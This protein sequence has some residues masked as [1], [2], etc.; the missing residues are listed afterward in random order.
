MYKVF[1]TGA[2]GYIGGHLVES[3]LAEGHHVRCLLRHNGRKAALPIQC[4]SNLEC[5]TGDLQDTLRLREW[6]RDCDLVYHLAGLTSARFRHDLYRTNVTG[7]GAVAEACAMQRRPPRLIIVSSLAAAGTATKGH[8]RSSADASRPVSEYGRSKRAGELAAIR[9]ANQVPIS[10]VRPGIVFGERNREMLP[11]FQSIAQFRLHAVP[12]YV[13]RRVSLV[14]HEDLITLLRQIQQRGRTVRTNGSDRG[15]GIYF[16]AD[17]QHVSYA[18]L[19]RMIARSL[20]QRRALILPIAEP[21]AWL[22][23][24]G[25]QG[26]NFLRGRSDSF[27]LDKM[28]EA[29]AGDWIGATESLQSEFNFRPAK[30]LQARL[31]QTAR[32]YREQGWVS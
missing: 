5:V 17:P 15:T 28:R 16:A 24:A 9:W 1:V 2:T 7:S 13:P 14:H 20:G 6:L 22:V 12:G 29:F 31:D 26:V 4:H 18:E 25:N 3:L 10:I 27:N 19:G 8:A 30:S 21:L 32:W 11:L 23:A